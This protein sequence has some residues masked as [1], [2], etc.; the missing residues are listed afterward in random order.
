[1]KREFELKLELEG[2]AGE[3]LRNHPLLAAIQATRAKQLSI[4][5]DTARGKLRK[6]GLTLRVREKAGKFIQTIKGEGSSAGLFDREEWEREVA[7][8]WPEQQ[9]CEGTPLEALLAPRGFAKLKPVIRADVERSAWLLRHE[10]A[11]IEIVLDE[12]EVGAAGETRLVNEVEIERLEGSAGAVFSVAR[13][14]ADQVP[15]RLGVLSKAESGFALA[16]GRF[17]KPS[18]AAPIRLDPAMRAREGIGVILLACLRHFR[19]NEP[20]VLERRDADALHQ[21]RVAMRRLR[22][23]LSLFAPVLR[24]EALGALR[25]ELRWFTSQLGEARNLDVYLSRLDNEEQRP[26]VA[27]RR[28]LAYDSVVLAMDSPRQRRLMLDLVEWAYCGEWRRSKKAG[29]PLATIAGRRL[30]GRWLKIVQAGER[31]ADMGEEPRHRLRID[32]KKLRYGLEFLQAL[33]QDQARRQK[34]FLRAIEGLQEELGHLNDLVT[35]RT[36]AVEVG[37]AGTESVSAA[38]SD[39]GASSAEAQHLADAERHFRALKRAAGYWR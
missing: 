2:D 14:I 1:M 26:P 19:L 21:A 29:L 31:I 9:A 30:D 4:Y 12:G 10:Q 23:A 36:I 37:Q 34:K 8:P 11:Q 5:F 22:A 6:A 39:I 20:L 24:D 7:G 15:V 25:E 3:G 13:L 18:K 32:V 27:D 33:H 16:D 17:S 35:A 28:E 38:A